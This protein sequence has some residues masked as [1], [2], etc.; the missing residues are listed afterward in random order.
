M[1]LFDGDR[2]GY[3]IGAVA[4]L[5]AAAIVREFRLG[6][7]DLGRPLAKATIKSCI[8]LT[9]RGRELFAHISEVVED[10]TIEARLELDEQYSAGRSP[11]NGDVAAAAAPAQEPEAH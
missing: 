5:A 6:F 11:G 2:K 9:D 7:R 4:G 3:I 10:L 1:D 8:A